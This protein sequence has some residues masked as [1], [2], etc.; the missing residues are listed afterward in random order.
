MGLFNRRPK[1]E[2]LQKKYEA[3]LRDWHHLSTSNRRA[4]DLKYSEAQMVLEEIETLR[5]QNK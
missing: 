4:S 2:R 3:L 1:I 5:M